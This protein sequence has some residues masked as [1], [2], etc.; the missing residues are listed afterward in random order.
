M[1]HYL[2]LSALLLAGFFLGSC[3]EDKING[4]EPPVLTGDA[5]M[6]KVS[7]RN[8]T[9]TRALGDPFTAT[10]AEKAITKLSFYVYPEKDADKEFVPFQRY[11]FDM[12][13]LP[14]NKDSVKITETA[15]GEYDCDFILR[16]GGGFSCRI[17]ALANL[18]DDFDETNNLNTYAKLQEAILHADAMPVVASA[19]PKADNQYGLVMYA[20]DAKMIKKSLE[21]GMTFTMQR[22]AA[23]IDITNRAFDTEN[24]EKGFVLTSA[25]IVNAKPGSFLI[26]AATTASLLTRN[27]A[28]VNDPAKIIGYSQDGTDCKTPTSGTTDING[29]AIR[30]DA[31]IEA[32]VVEQRLWHELY[33]YENDDE[34]T[35]SAT[36]VLIKGKFRN[37]PF[38]RVIPFVNSKGDPVIIERNHRYLIR[39]NP[40]PDLTDV[41]FNIQVTDWDAVD[42]VN[43]KPTQKVVPELG[44]FAAGFIPDADKKIAL[45]AATGTFTFEAVNPFDT[46]CVIV[47]EPDDADA[48]AGDEH[49]LDW[50]SVS[51][52]DPTIVTKASTGYKRTY[53]VQVDELSDAGTRRSMLLIRNK[54][55]VTARDTLHI[56]QTKDVV[57][58][59]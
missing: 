40:A 4:G 41:S 6:L 24:P 35:G 30:T 26:P 50:I 14:L 44:N 17:V 25:N 11:V 43:V 28:E 36:S 53:T 29:N 3:T 46:D 18:P 12:T 7:F 45:A 23:R 32:G 58:P 22:L 59:W 37:S 38:S 39:I 8:G 2:Y 10:D 27:F 15:K 33:T 1:K 49:Y 9:S 56:S 52:S 5:A 48:A 42:T 31:T 51:A 47:P 13:T 55:N 21:T 34:D 16:E 19:D 54:A 20:E 57:A